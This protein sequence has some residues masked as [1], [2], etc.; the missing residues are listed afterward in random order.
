M[1]KSVQTILV[2]HTGTIAG[3]LTD[4]AKTEANIVLCSGKF[5]Q[6][7]NIGKFS[8]LDYLGEKTLVHG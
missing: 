8:S 2:S 3:H 6:E 5:W 7:K 1:Y 4:S